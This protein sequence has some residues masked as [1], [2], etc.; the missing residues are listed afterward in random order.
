MS[1]KAVGPR[2]CDRQRPVGPQVGTRPI[3]GGWP[4]SGVAGNR[5]L[6][7]VALPSSS[8]SDFAS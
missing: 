3:R 2:L 4:Y 7:L 6:R 1:L 8:W 5:H